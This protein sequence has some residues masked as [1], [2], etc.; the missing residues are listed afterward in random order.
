MFVFMNYKKFLKPIGRITLI[1]MIGGLILGIVRLFQGS[2]DWGLI[3]MSIFYIIF[4]FVFLPFLE[5]VNKH[6]KS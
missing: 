1:V 4:L 5:K 2:D 3:N 6:P